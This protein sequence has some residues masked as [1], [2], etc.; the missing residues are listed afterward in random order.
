MILNPKMV[1][2][3]GIAA[4]KDVEDNCSMQKYVDQ[5]EEIVIDAVSA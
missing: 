2:D 4:R 1:Q 5:I 3:I